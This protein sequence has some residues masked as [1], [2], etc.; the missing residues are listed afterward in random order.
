MRQ[1][2][3]LAVLLLS[4]IVALA[5]NR[6]LTGLLKNAQT[7]EGVPSATIRVK[8]KNIQTTTDASGSFSL[9]VP[10]GPVVLEITSVGYAAKTVSIEP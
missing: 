5:Q 3:L 8:G 6:T 7:G 10:A 2:C 9:S 4:G 1:V